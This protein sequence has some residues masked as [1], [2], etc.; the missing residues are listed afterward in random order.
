MEGEAA[1]PA[2]KEQ[3]VLGTVLPAGVATARAALTGVV[4]IHADAAIARQGRLVGQE[5]AEFRKG[6]LRSMPI[7][8]ARFGGNGNELLALAAPRAASA[9]LADARE[10]FQ[11]DETRGMGVQDLPGDGVVGAQL[12][13]SRLPGLS[14]FCGGSHCECLGAGAVV[15]HG[16]SGRLSLSPARRE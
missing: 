4:G 1:V 7:G 12:E 3:A 14:P 16:R 2:H 6:P 10:V 9:S 8:P 11:A 5:A 13:P 15:G